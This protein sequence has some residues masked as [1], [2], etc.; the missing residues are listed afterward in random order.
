MSYPSSLAKKTP[1]DNLKADVLLL[2]SYPKKR[3]KVERIA[4][5][6]VHLPVLP[7]V[8]CS[9]RLLVAV[10]RRPELLHRGKRGVD[11]AVFLTALSSVIAG[12]WL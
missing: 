12:D 6:P 5:F 1:F 2:D 9:L 8:D 11:P 10:L 4:P 3:R 7:P